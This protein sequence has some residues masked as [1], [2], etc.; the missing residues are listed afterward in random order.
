MVR[1]LPSYFSSFVLSFFFVF[2]RSASRMSYY[3]E[4]LFKE[5]ADLPD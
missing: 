1:H 2:G 5:K 4:S 3:D